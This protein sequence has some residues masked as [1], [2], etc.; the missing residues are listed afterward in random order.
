MSIVSSQK[1]LN[2]NELKELKRKSDEV[3]EMIERYSGALALLKGE[4][5]QPAQDAQ[6]NR[7]SLYNQLSDQEEI[8]EQCDDNISKTSSQIFRTRTSIN[9]KERG[10]LVGRG[11][12]GKRAPKKTYS[13]IPKFPTV[14]LFQ[15]YNLKI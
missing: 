6:Q 14:N 9:S 12:Q 2:L 13:S 15:F 11:S 3:F 7:E 8:K 4:G 5:A 1:P 10:S